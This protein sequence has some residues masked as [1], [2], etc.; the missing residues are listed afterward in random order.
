[1]PCLSLQFNPLVGPL[2]LLLV[3]PPASLRSVTLPAGAPLPTGLQP[4]SVA[5]A[6]ALIDTGATLTCITSNIAQ[7]AG[8][9]L[10]GKRPMGTAGGVVPTNVYLAD[11]VIP[12]SAITAPAQPQLAP[13]ITIE[14]IEVMEFQCASPHYQALMGRD[15]IC[16]GILH[17]GFDGRVTFSI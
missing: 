14:S 7:Q 13:G 8:L 17:I 5:S 10:I 2:I 15:I 3:A 12:L 4:Q 1:M 16:R 9:P 6:P 11:V